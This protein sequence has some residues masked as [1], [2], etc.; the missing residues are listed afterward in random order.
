MKKIR[1]M[2]VIRAFS[3]FL[4]TII[5]FRITYHKVDFNFKK[6]EITLTYLVNIV[7]FESLE[8]F[9]ISSDYKVSHEVNMVKTFKFKVT[10]IVENFC[11]HL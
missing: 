10:L 11:W 5:I 4:M 9:L 3:Y 1:M 6:C 2:F 7:S 8:F